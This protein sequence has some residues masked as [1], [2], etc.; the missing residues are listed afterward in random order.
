[1]TGVDENVLLSPLL[2]SDPPPDF[3]E[4]DYYESAN[5]SYRTVNTDLGKR[6]RVP[7]PSMRLSRRS[8]GVYCVQT[9]AKLLWIPCPVPS[10][11][12]TAVRYGEEE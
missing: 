10:G 6:C 3:P 9:D 8:T 12:P 11:E 2:R 7:H 1:M 4:T 5:S